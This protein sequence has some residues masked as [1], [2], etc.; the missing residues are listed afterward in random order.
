MRLSRSVAGWVLL[1]ALR[2]SESLLFLSLSIYIYYI[3]IHYIYIRLCVVIKIAGR[4]HHALLHLSETWLDKRL[5]IGRRLCDCDWLLGF[6]S[7]SLGRQT[8]ERTVRTDRL[9]DH[10]VSDLTSGLSDA[11][12]GLRNRQTDCKRDRRPIRSHTRDLCYR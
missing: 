2:H 12:I 6:V 11:E 5:L 1:F 7:R 8:D 10:R 3:Y 9:S 4:L